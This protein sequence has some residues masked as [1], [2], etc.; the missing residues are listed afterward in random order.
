M[1]KRIRFLTT[2]ILT[3]TF[4]L[5]TLNCSNG[6][7]TNSDSQQS[8]QS[9]ENPKLT[10]T[11]LMTGLQL[12]WDLAFAPDGTMYYTE[13]CIGVSARKSDGTIKHL[14]GNG[15]GAVLT[16]PDLVCQSQSAMLGLALDPDFKN[17]R[18]LYVFMASNKSDPIKNR[19]VRVAFNADFTSAT[20]TDIVTDLAFKAKE[21]EWGPV[22]AHSG[23][24][25]RFGPDGFLYITTG[26]NQDA[27][28][29][30]DLHRLGGKIIRVD[31]DGNA[32]PGNN[33]PNGGDPR[34]FTYGHRNV[35]GVCFHPDT[36]KVFIAE[37]GPNHSDEVTMLTA[38]GNGGWDPRPDPGVTCISDYCGY[39]PKN[40]E[41]RRKFM[42]ELLKLQ[43][44]MKPLSSEDL[45]RGT[46]PC[47]FLSGPQW[48]AWDRAMVIGIMAAKDLDVLKISN[49]GHLIERSTA[50]MPED[51][52]R[53]TVQ[54]PDGNL[55][56]STD[57]GDIL[58]VSP[59]P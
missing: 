45:R 14:F 2:A 1:Q 58:K 46:G 56:I 33:T 8:V 47:T 35:Q 13:M 59:Q 20:R 50:E 29:P 21:T 51:R 38:G 55:Y 30:Q 6:D 28:L 18:T 53:T 43:K 4:S 26:D 16:A 36:N 7:S 19:I 52:F 44:A 54:G 57:S 41:G 27:L 32:A 17:N 42:T 25:I 12:P 23:G 31:R 24:R 49:A 10:V 3:L 48:K 34:I 9:Q 15:P 22:G 11:K 40:L 5:F 39:T 37:H